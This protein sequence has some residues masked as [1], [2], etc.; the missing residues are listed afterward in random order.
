M[1]KINDKRRLEKYILN[2]RINE[3]FD[4]DIKC[5][6]ELFYFKRNEYICK[7]GEDV[8]YLFFFVEGK[9]KIYITMSNGKSLLICFYDDF[10]IIGDME[11][12]SVKPATNNVQA[13]QDTYCI[14]ISMETAR[15]YLLNDV[16]FLRFMCGSLGDKLD[17]CSNNCSIN[18]LY[19]L[20]NRLASYILATGQ[21]LNCNG[22]SVIKINENLKEISELLGTSYRH[23]IRTFNILIEKGGIIK[24]NGG[25][26][27]ADEEILKKLSADL[28]K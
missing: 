4:N 26:E 20:E 5:F 28:Y 18:L 10:R 1:I 3:I 9:V 11:M 14:G 16:K 7:E 22:K 17:K 25:Y 23:L 21:K 27:V 15:K 6:M 8:P 2:H 13:I 24:N 19:P 12:M